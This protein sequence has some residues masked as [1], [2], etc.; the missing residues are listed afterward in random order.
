MMKSMIRWLLTLTVLI[1]GCGRSKDPSGGSSAQPAKRVVQL[2]PIAQ[3]PPGRTVHVAVD[4]RGNIFYVV[5]TEQQQDGVLMVGSGGIPRATQLTSANILAAMGQTVGGAG[6]IQSL[7]A[8]P[9]GGLFFSFIGGKGRAIYA[10]VGH[11][12]SRQQTM[13]ILFGTDQ[14]KTATGFGDSL[15]IARTT[16]VPMK[17]RIGLFV[18][19]MDNWVFFSF[20]AV[21]RGPA[22][23]P[24]LVRGFTK[25]QA[26]EMEIKL[27]NDRYELSGG[28]G[29]SLL[30]MDR[31]TGLLW[32][33]DPVKG[34]GVFRL[35]LRGLPRELSTPLAID[36]DRLLMF[37]ADSELI[38]ADVNEVLFSQ[39]PQ[40]AY[41]ALLEITD[42]KIS[43]IGRQDLRAPAGFPVHWL[44]IRQLLAC[45]DGSLVGY[46]R[47]SGMLMRITLLSEQIRP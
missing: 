38:D 21:L 29:A 44:M 25:V 20:D 27:S 10:C 30:L 12:N 19:H 26:D 18:R 34:M 43:A 8:S 6:N 15:A 16:L 39:I 31:V 41:P 35:L 11:F 1:A 23:E 24:K 36:N 13:R 5:E 2:Q 45:P 22:F 33:V 28:P 7:V 37:A 17:D 32:Q 46:D 3:L 42:K 14:L 4:P 47:A 40:T 9:E